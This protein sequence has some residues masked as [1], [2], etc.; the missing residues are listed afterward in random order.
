[1][2]IDANNAVVKLGILIPNNSVS[3]I[4]NIQ[5]LMIKL[6]NPNVNRLTGKEMSKMIGLTH[7]LII[8]STLPAMIRSNPLL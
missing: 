8:H 4:N 6:N 1:M 2:I 3:V 5:V 7:K